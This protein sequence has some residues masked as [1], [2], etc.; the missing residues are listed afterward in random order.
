MKRWPFVLVFLVFAGLTLAQEGPRSRSPYRLP[1]T[2]WAGGILLP[3]FVQYD[4]YC[5]GPL[6]W[7]VAVDGIAPVLERIRQNHMVAWGEGLKRVEFRTPMGL[8][9]EACAKL[10]ADVALATFRSGWVPLLV[11]YGSARSVDELRRWQAQMVLRDGQGKV[12]MTLP[13]YDRYPSFDQVSGRLEG[14]MTYMFWS[15]RG[16]TRKGVDEYLELVGMVDRVYAIE[17]RITR[18]GKEEVYRI[19]YVDYPDLW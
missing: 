13:Y 14:S 2:T 16:E 11:V 5:N 12:L 6:V 8:A 4:F 19:R 18:G 17:F 15:A 9:L 1:D 10:G 7:R 3:A